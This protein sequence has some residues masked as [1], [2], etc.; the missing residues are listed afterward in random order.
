MIKPEFS[1]ISLY[2]NNNH[3]K[4]IIPNEGW[5]FKA[6]YSLL[7]SIICNVFV[8]FALYKLSKGSCIVLFFLP[9]FALSIGSFLYFLFNLKGQIRIIFDEKTIKVFWK[10]YQIRY[11][12]WGKSKELYKIVEYNTADKDDLQKFVIGLYFENGDIIKFGNDLFDE[13]RKWL[14]AELDT[15][16]AAFKNKQY[17]Q[18]EPSHP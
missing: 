11:S 17:T 8:G 6:K 5:S 4:I 14:I 1:K 7:L 10:L 3:H 16:N 9:L 18:N 15:I 12:R 2:L 13:E